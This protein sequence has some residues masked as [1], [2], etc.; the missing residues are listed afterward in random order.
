MEK[1]SKT[2]VSPEILRP[3]YETQIEALHL[4]HT[5][6][7]NV[8]HTRVKGRRIGKVMQGGLLEEK[9]TR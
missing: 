1:N 2:K 8:L 6:N 9:Q 4:E 7:Q 3:H 5:S